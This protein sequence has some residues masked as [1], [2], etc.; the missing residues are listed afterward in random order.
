MRS[1]LHIV[2]F[3]ILNFTADCGAR[4]HVV[5]KSIGEKAHLT[6]KE[7]RNI[8]TVKW[9]KDHNLIAAVDNKKP[10]IK[11]PAK[12]HIRASDNSLFIYNLTVNDSGYYKA[13]TGLWEEEII[14]YNLTVQEAVSIPKI[15]FKHQHWLNSSSDCHIL[16]KCSA[17]GD[18]V[19]YD[20]DPPAL[21]SDKCHIHQGLEKVPAPSSSVDYIF[22][23]IILICG[24]VVLVVLLFCFI[25]YLNNSRKKEQNAGTYQ[26]DKDVNTVYSVVCKQPSTETPADSIDAEN[27]VTSIY[28]VPSNRVRVSQCDSG[29]NV[30]NDDTHTVYWKLGQTHEQ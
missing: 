16:V 8:T 29:D 25:K 2:T 12:F 23:L 17:D 10:A 24:A 7:H 9:R 30:Q 1:Y 19:T 22:I 26:D 4:V 11:N 20:C 15:D 14:T 18:S 21:H 13:E 3:I 27:A 6:L 28:D 5:Y